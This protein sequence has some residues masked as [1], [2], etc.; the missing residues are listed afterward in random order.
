MYWT[1]WKDDSDP[2]NGD[3]EE[4]PPDSSEC[5][6]PLVIQVQSVSGVN[7]SHLASRFANLSRSFQ[8]P[9]AETGQVFEAFSAER[10]FICRREHQP[11]SACQDYRVRYLCRKSETIHGCSRLDS[12]RELFNLGRKMNRNS[13]DI[14]SKSVKSKQHKPCP[15]VVAATSTPQ[16]TTHLTKGAQGRKNRGDPNK[17]VWTPWSNTDTPAGG[18]DRELLSN[19]ADTAGFC[20]YDIYNEVTS[21]AT[22]VSMACIFQKP[23]I[24][25]SANR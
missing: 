16:T 2:D 24:H 10:G 12:K 18:G 19:V 4:L 1:S 14:S 11:K 5:K 21:S 6:R 22:N 15:T 17:I 20:K 3:D 7:I 23:S 9:S 13:T 25:R 8:V